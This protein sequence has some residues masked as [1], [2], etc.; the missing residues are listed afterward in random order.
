L[1]AQLDLLSEALIGRQGVEVD[2]KDLA[3]LVAQCDV[4]IAGIKTVQV[5]FNVIRVE[6]SQLCIEQ[7]VKHKIIQPE[8]Q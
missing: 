1:I 8:R 6:G 5:E 3:K 7:L 4:A 2:S